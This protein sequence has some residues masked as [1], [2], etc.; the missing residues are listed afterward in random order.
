MALGFELDAQHSPRRCTNILTPSLNHLPFFD[1]RFFVRPT[2]LEVREQPNYLQYG[3]IQV[4]A[5]QPV[6]ASLKVDAT[7]S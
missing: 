5:L 1:P 3:R 2:V 4:G 6:K 7:K